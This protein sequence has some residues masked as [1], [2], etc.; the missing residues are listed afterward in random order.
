MP[1]KISLFKQLLEFNVLRDILR[2]V[3]VKDKNC[4]DTA[5]LLRLVLS[6]IGCS[7]L[8]TL[9]KSIK[10][11]SADSF[12]DNNVVK[13]F[14]DGGVTDRAFT[15]GGSGF[16]EDGFAD[17]SADYADDNCANGTEDGSVNG[18]TNSGS[19]NGFGCN[20]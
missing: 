19:A 5:S 12:T 8:S 20:V 16:T 7:L 9:I 18:F 17:G 14:A 10:G 6:Y 3:K 15:D 1:F 4:N 13:G 11:G 2:T